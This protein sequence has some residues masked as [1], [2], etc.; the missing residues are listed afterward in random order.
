MAS[1]SQ[2]HHHTNRPS[3]GFELCRKLAD[4]ESQGH[5]RTTPCSGRE[6][7]DI[8]GGTPRPSPSSALAATME[9][10]MSRA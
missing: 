9:S 3:L 10:R 4:A 7:A 1:E 8:R 6:D 2:W 5:Q